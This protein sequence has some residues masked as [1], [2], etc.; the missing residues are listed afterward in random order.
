MSQNYNFTVGQGEDWTLDVN[1][2]DDVGNLLDLTGYTYA[3]QMRDAYDSTNI[4]ATFTFTIA[5]Q[6]TNK[7]RV[8]FSLTHEQTTGIPLPASTGSQKRPTKEYLYD[9]IETDALGKVQRILDGS[10]IVTAGITK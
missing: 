10:V 7:G 3:G 1:M 2:K 9:I 8:T 6:I 5:N 4:I